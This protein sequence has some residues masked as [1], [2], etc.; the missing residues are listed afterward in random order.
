M[1]ARLDWENVM[2]NPAW[3][4]TA[5]GK[6]ITNREYYISGLC[7]Y[8]AVGITAAYPGDPATFGVNVNYKFGQ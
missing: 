4:V 3:S 2:G 7:L 1:N 6:N 5:W 8:N